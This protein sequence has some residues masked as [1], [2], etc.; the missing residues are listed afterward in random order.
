MSDKEEPIKSYG[1]IKQEESDDSFG[2]NN[3]EKIEKINQRLKSI[4]S[5]ESIESVDPVCD[6]ITN[7]VVSEKRS[8]SKESTSSNE[9]AGYY[10]FCSIS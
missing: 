10:M 8:E 4:E 7:I 2:Y 6:T 1:T 5:V 3:N 9:S